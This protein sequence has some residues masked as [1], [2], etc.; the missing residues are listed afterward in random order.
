MAE[1][2]IAA[3]PVKF[4]F[5]FNNDFDNTLIIRLIGSTNLELS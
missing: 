1:I 2:A 5:H 3:I 4:V